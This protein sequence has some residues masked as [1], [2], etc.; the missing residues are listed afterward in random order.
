MGKANR[1][2]KPAPP[3]DDENA[4]GPLSAAVASPPCLPDD[5]HGGARAHRRELRLERV[6]VHREL[7]FAVPGALSPD[8]CR[9][10]IAYGRRAG[11]ERAHHAEGGGVAFRDNG[12]LALEHAPAPAAA[13]FARLAPFVPRA[14]GARRAA[15]CNPHIRLYEYAPGQRFG[16]H[17]DESARVGEAGETEY[18]V[19]VYLNGGED[20]PLRGGETVFYDADAASAAAAPRGRRGKAARGPP[21]VAAVVTPRQG[22]ALVHAHG[23]RCLLHEGAAVQAGVKYLLRTDVAYEG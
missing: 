12:R 21:P 5:A 16:A 20:D 17:Y 9:A 18:T 6:P 4:A 14:L 10:W 23:A 15:G 8:E 2:T 11:F 3:P 19:L 13:L 22:T 7:V 1:T